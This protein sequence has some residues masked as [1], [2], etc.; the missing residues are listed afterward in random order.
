M[1]CLI[2]QFIFVMSYD[3]YKQ[4]LIGLEVVG[5]GGKLTQTASLPCIGTDLV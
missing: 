1:N 5:T 3:F 2:W 4:L